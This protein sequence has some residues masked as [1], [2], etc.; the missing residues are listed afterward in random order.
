MK[1]ILALTTLFVA[2]PFI[3]NSQLNDTIFYK[4][5]TSKA[6]EISTFDDNAIYY[7][8]SNKKDA[9]ESSISRATVA[10]FKMYDNEG[11]L[12]F[13]SKAGTQEVVTTTTTATVTEPDLV[14][15]M[16]SKE[17]AVSEHTL[18]FN[19]FLLTFLSAN[20]K[21]NY[22][23][24]DKMQY[25]ITARATY[26]SDLLSEFN[27][28]GDLMLGAGFRINPLHVKHFGFGVD[29]T[30]T[31]GIFTNSN[32]NFNND[33]YFLF[34]INANF[35][36]LFNER[37]GITVDAGLGTAYRSGDYSYMGRFHFGLLWQFK[38][39]KTYERTY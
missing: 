12:T 27:F 6:V 33:P 15:E 3:G 34:P 14:E 38:S 23:F 7:R 18:S 17:I 29:V 28:F 22:T 11:V 26:L 9:K 32:N 39:K 19:P 37:L 1:K 31:I 35:D 13:D 10:A 21:Y 25:G 5:G 24:G 2:L 20:L 36:F 8:V 30:P 16:T 4:S